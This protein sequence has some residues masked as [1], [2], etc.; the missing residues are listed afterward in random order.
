[1]IIYNITTRVGWEIHEEWLGWLRQQCLPGIIGT[2][3]FTDFQLVRVKEVSEEEG[4]T[5]AVQLF[6]KGEPELN[7]YRQ[8]HLEDLERTE[9]ENWG[10]SAFSFKT[11]LEVIN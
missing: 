10:E 11:V 8:N 3:L 5:Y 4:P 9:W 6:A 1:M 7:L 2:G